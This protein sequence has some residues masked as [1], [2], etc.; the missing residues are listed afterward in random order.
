[1]IPLS[2]ALTTSHERGAFRRRAP[3]IIAHEHQ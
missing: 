1:M 2:S 3:S